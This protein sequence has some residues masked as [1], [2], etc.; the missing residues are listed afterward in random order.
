[1]LEMEK[2]G[3]EA[4]EGRRR[5]QFGRNRVAAK[6]P[7]RLSGGHRELNLP[8]GHRQPETK[9]AEARRPS[10]AFLALMSRFR[11]GGR[12]L[13]R[14]VSFPPPARNF[15]A[16]ARPRIEVASTLTGQ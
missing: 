16:D 12:R 14:Q 8:S 13:V 6:H 15:R 3:N 5:R 10:S 4:V 2:Y 7:R 1:M 9:R 11:S